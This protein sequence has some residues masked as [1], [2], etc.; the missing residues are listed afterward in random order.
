MEVLYVWAPPL[1]IGELRRAANDQ[2]SFQYAADWIKNL[3]SFSLSFSLKLNKDT[4]YYKEAEFFFANLLPEG[5]A[6]ETLC[7]KMGVSVDNDFELLKQIGRDCA[8]ALV[9]TDIKE[10]DKEWIDLKEILREDLERWLQQ[11]ST[12]ILDLQ[13][14]GELRISLAGA[15]NKLPLVYHQNKFFHPL[16]SH[17]TTHILKPP[18]DRFKYL[19]ENEWFQAQLAEKMGLKVAPSKLIKIDKAWG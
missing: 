14:A 11:G 13:V 10:L 5:S 19:P 9:I 17:P 4:I 3:N 8:G 1:L 16:G 12:G 18:P 2:I 7:R 6:R 15:Q